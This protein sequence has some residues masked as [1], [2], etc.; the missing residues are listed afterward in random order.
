MIIND[1]FSKKQSFATYNLQDIAGLIQ[2]ENVVLREVNK[3]HVRAIKK[4]ILDNVN[5]EQIYFPPIVAYV[6]PGTLAAGKPTKFTIIDGNQRLKALSQL[7]EMAQR[8]IK[9]DRD[10]DIEKGYKLLS[11]L[12]SSAIGVLFYEGL[13]ECEAG[14]L[15]IDLNTKGK[16]VALPKRIAFDSR[17][18]LN[19]ITNKILKTNQKLQLAG[20]E[21]EKRAIIRPK[22]KKLLSLTHLRQIVTIFL[23]GRM[24][25]RTGG[26][27]QLYLSSNDYLA[28]LDI[29]F[30]ELFQLY[31][32]ESIGNYAESMLANT[33]LLLAVAYYANKGLALENFEERKVELVARMRPLRKVNWKRTSRVWRKFKGDLKGCDGYFYFSNDKENVELLVS[34]LEQQG[35]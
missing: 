11:Y 24:V 26:S 10:E 12:K 23:T 35:R 30:E 18:E 17:C 20:V 2:T 25:Y 14:Q 28:L 7:E 1:I 4:Y 19:Q 27:Y 33:T 31:R 6:A 32:P 5:Q 13:T 9:S 22:N 16:K 15:Y 8:E 3:L 34:W 29:W 21:T